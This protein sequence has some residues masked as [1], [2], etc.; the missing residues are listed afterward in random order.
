M[1]SVV[2]AIPHASTALPPE[3]R[4]AYLPRV[5]P[6]FLR[7]Q[8]DVDTDVV[9]ALSNVRT[10]RYGY[11][12]FLADPNR[13]EQQENEGGVVP[14]FDFDGESIYKPGCVPDGE[15]QW[16][17]VLKYHRPYH[18][19]VARAVDDPRTQFFIDAHSMA[20]TPPR[21]SPDFGRDRPD[22]VISNRGDFLGL[23]MENNLTA[24][25][26]TRGGGDLSCPAELVQ[27]LSDRLAFWLGRFPV[28]SPARGRRPTTEVRINDPFPGGHGVRTHARPDEGI[29]GIQLELNQGLWI[30]QET[31]E[32]IPGRMDWIK[33]V[34]TR[35]I[36]DV[37]E[38]RAGWELDPMT[39]TLEHAAVDLPSA[40]GSR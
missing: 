22:A 33:R 36:E 34:M 29:P 10:V 15:E 20:Q 27:Q 25:D 32:R 13:G 18:E 40:A 17:R 23:M 5:T 38:L 8:S 6:L 1:P 24:S 9:Y 7:S 19:R 11:S 31:W 16:R 21:R 35:W 3:V 28:P 37:I 12:R 4:E 14:H 2:I 39:T 30:D 26:P